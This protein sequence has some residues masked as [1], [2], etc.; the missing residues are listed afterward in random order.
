VI[1]CV[2]G[3]DRVVC[4]DWWLRLCARIGGLGCVQGTDRVVVKELVACGQGTDRVVCKDVRRCSRRG[5]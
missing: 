5:R 1:G 2:Q 4:K 3:T